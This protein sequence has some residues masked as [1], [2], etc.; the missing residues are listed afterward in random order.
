MTNTNTNTDDESALERASRRQI[1]ASAAGIA[2]A[3][4][5]GVTFAGSATAA[6]TG[7]FPISSDP[8]LLKIRA[9]RIR[10]VPRTSDP[11]APDGGTMWVV[12]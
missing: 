3:G 10:F 11:S 9:D 12:E 8:A 7:T 1:L 5:A 4:A 6:P 2:A